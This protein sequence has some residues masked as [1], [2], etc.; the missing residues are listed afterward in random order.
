MVLNDLELSQQVLVHDGGY[1]I[2]IIS[3][4]EWSDI[5]VNQFS[6]DLASEALLDQSL[7]VGLDL[8]QWLSQT[9]SYK[10]DTWNSQLNKWHILA[11]HGV[12]DDISTYGLFHFSGLVE[13]GEF[14]N[15]FDVH[16]F[17]GV[18][19][20]VDWGTDVVTDGE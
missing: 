20:A 3:L 16:G 4:Q 14:L 8:Y 11:H 1:L 9:A 10:V 15:G 2:T 12:L 6:L 13:I 7:Q 19:D 5:T 18:L 17:S